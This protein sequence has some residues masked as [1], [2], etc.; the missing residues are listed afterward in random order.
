MTSCGRKVDVGG[1][2]VCVINLR[3]VS[4]LQN[5]VL[6]SD[7]GLDDESLVHYFFF[8]ALQLPL[9]TNQRTKTGEAWG[10]GHMEPQ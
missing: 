7:G 1:A 6:P 3:E 9:N 5:N 2:S 8:A 10:Q 4:P